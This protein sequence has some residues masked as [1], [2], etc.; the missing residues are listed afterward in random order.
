MEVGIRHAS[1]G[2]GL[3]AE[4]GISLAIASSSMCNAAVRSE[5]GSCEACLACGAVNSAF[6]PH[7]FVAATFRVASGI[8]FAARNSA[9][10]KSYS[11]VFSK[12]QK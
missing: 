11:G 3:K 9:T 1:S 12:I 5:R 10:R 7:G 6:R 4:G 2:S 8:D